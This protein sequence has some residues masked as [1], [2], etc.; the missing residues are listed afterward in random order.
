[1]QFVQRTDLALEAGE[2][3]GDVGGV[4]TAKGKNWQILEIT[5]NAAAE[6]LGKPVGSY[7]TLELDAL[8]RREDAAFEQTARQLAQV[9]AGKL[10]SEG[11][12]L[13]AG[14]GNSSITPDALGTAAADNILV[15]RHL[16][17]QMP[18]DFAGFRSVA[19]TTPGVLGT[20]GIE[21]A[22][23][24]SALCELVRPC[25]LIAIDALAAR[26]PERLCRTVQVTDSGVTPGSGVGNSRQELSFSSLGVPVIA[27]GVPTVVDI[28]TL[29]TDA[30]AEDA[31]GGDLIVTP[32]S[33]DSQ[34]AVAGRLVGYAVNLALHK[35]LTVADIDMLLG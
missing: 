28:S 14:L 18:Q 26:R 5:T 12:V 24:V 11:T 22:S 20:S 17:S 7:Y 13:I 1:M 21:S 32:R 33:I 3:A 9:I 35:G 10:P 4:K 34:I 29:L 2:L 30:G 19:V 6:A 23:Y 16:K 31:A 25:A 15:T 27:I 8:L